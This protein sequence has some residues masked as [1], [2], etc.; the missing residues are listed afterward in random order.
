MARCGN[1]GEQAPE[2]ARFC[3]FCGASLESAPV[4]ERKRVSV[5]F[6]DMVGSTAYAGTADVEDVR[7]TLAIFQGLVE[8]RLASFGA[9]VEKFIGDAAVAVFGAPAAHE[10]DPERAVRAAIAIRDAVLARNERQEQPE[11]HVRI[12]VQTGEALV[13]VSSDPATGERIATGDVLNVA[14]RL[15]SAAP[16]DGIFVGEP[17]HRATRDAIEYGDATSIEAKGKPLPVA[18]WVALRP[19]A[20][21]GVDLSRRVSTALVDRRDE[22]AAILAAFDAA[23]GGNGP[24]TVLLVGS[25]GIGKSRLAWELASHLERAPDIVRWR[26]GRTP[27]Y[28]EDVTFYALAEMVKA[29]AGI[30]DSDG[31]E[32]AARKLAESVHALVDGRDAEWVERHLRGLVGFESAPDLRGDRRAEAFAAWRRFLDALSTRY[33]LVL[34]FEDLH[35]ADDA[36]LDFIEHLWTWASSRLLILVTARPELLDRRPGWTSAPGATVVRVGPLSNSDAADLLEGLDPSAALDQQ[37]RTQLLAQAGG[38]PLYAVEF[39][40]LLVDQRL[41]DD[42]DAALPVP[43]SVLAIIA[44]RI[45]AL[46]AG[47]KAVLQDAAVVGRVFWPGAV[48]AVTGRGVWGVTEVLRSLEEREIVRRRPES[49]VQ[50]ELEFAFV[51][52]LVRDVAYGTIVRDARAGKHCLAAA[53]IEQLAADRRDRAGTLAHHYDQALLAT[54]R[55]DPELRSRAAGAFHEAADHAL[56][57]HSHA[58]AVDL[59]ARALELAGADEPRRPRLLLTHAIALALVD[60]PALEALETASRALSEAGDGEG[61]AE[62]ESTAAW[63]RAIAGDMDAARAHDQRALEMVAGRPASRAKALVLC[64]AGTHLIFHPEHR[65]QGAALLDEALELARA[66]RMRE[67]EAEALQFAGMGRISAGDLRGRDDVEA[68][69][70]LAQDANSE[71]SLSCYGNL[72]DVQKRLGALER[73]AA[74]TE[75]GLAA[76]VR[77]GMAVQVRRFRAEAALYRF[78]SGSW[79]EA[80]RIADEY[81]SATEAGLHHQMEAEMR[82]LRGRIKLARGEVEEARREGERAMAFARKTGHPYDLLPALAFAAHASAVA[83]T[84]DAG[85]LTDEL[86][87]TLRSHQLFWAA[88]ALPDA[89]AAAVIHGREAELGAVLSAAGPST[90][91]ARA[92]LAQVDGRPLDAAGIYSEMGARPEEA[93]ARG[94]AAHRLGSEAGLEAA[95]A[96][97]RSVGATRELDGHAVR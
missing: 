25:P 60:R 18:A 22:W 72:A 95:T 47:D 32:A 17:T 1:C 44:A 86:L 51:H 38:N 10:D 35:W 31:T 21:T 34:A 92:A 16:V 5:V 82:V 58:Q 52:A 3:A 20:R 76:A 48:A 69:L 36:L 15:Q 68:A 73:A 65:L 59:S 13:A 39:L 61:A 96:F 53:W 43:E 91:W 11:F 8:R 74:L 56:A 88:L 9:T 97:W 41:L 37:A 67:I 78:W 7:H 90:P 77:F 42:G 89:V 6:V 28:G 24:R 81:L 66:Q 87:A 85:A 2:R 83:G 30:L 64:R 12:G 14:A 63:L 4:E 50:D 62:A 94:A 19:R 71:V 79:D 55:P 80:M 84:D 45:D 57:V 26:Q 75:E 46:P 40:R 93:A 29:E 54:P 70:A 33:P 27:A 23:Q 49:S